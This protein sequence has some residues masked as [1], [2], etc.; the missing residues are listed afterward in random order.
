V[1]PRRGLLMPGD[2]LPL[3]DHSGLGRSLTA[4]VLD[5]AL[6]EIGERRHAGFDLSVA[7]NLGPAD[8]LDLGLPSEVERLLGDHAFPAEALQLEVSEDVVMADIERTMEVL[9]GLRRVGVRTAL[10]DFGA[11]HS[12]LSHLKQLQVDVLKIDRGFVMRIADDHDAAIARSVIDL[13]RRLGLHVVAE[14]VETA[15]AWDLLAEWGCDE[16]Q[17]HLIGRAMPAAELAEWL[18]R[19]GPRVPS[20]PG[21]A[22]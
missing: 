21:R 10:D 15:E 17:G 18:R 9:V 3:A 14:G 6:E 4:F 22:R 8:L 16:A 11:G 20:R 7:V 13:G 2:F 12:A 5:R 19:P 1:H